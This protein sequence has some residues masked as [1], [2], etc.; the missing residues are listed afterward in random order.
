MVDSARSPQ[1]VVDGVDL[2]V[3]V[4]PPNVQ[5]ALVGCQVVFVE[6]PQ[7]LE[8]Q[9]VYSLTLPHAKKMFVQI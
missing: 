6:P 4:E 1:I 7:V 9:N 2:F 8:S 5:S 3:E